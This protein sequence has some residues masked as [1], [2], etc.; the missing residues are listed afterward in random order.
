MC[1]RCWFNVHI[2]ESRCLIDRWISLKNIYFLFR[3]STKETDPRGGTI[4]GK[5]TA[6]GVCWQNDPALRSPL[7]WMYSWE[8]SCNFLKWTSP[9]PILFLVDYTRRSCALLQNSGI[10]SFRDPVGIEGSKEGSTSPWAYLFKQWGKGVLGCK[11]G[12]LSWQVFCLY[13]LVKA[14]SSDQSTSPAS[15]LRWYFRSS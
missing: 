2:K 12:T 14:N 10:V 8:L 6:Y 7:H 13:L 4:L 5:M 9:R 3:Q 11:L 15:Y 1:S